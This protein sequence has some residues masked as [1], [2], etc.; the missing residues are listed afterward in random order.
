M[1]STDLLFGQSPNAPGGPVEIVFGD[2]DDATGGAV[3][4]RAS[5][6]IT[7]LRGHVVLRKAVQ[8]R[9]AGTITGLRGHIGARYDINVDRSMATA[10][11]QGWQQA[12]PLS[13]VIQGRYEQGVPVRGLHQ[14]VWQDASPLQHVLLSA[15][16]D[17]QR[18][19]RLAR[20]AWQEAQPLAPA[21]VL[22]AWQEAQRVRASALQR[23]EQ[24]QRVSAGTLQRYEE[25][26]RLRRATVQRFEQGQPRSAPVVTS[27]GTA[28][29]MSVLWV[30]RFEEARRPP[31]GITTTTQPQ[32]APCY[33][34]EL[35]THLVFDEPADSSLPAHLVFVCD[36]HTTDPEP[37]AVIV[38]PIKRYYVTLNNIALRRVDGDIELLAYGFTMSIDADSWTWSWSATLRR[39]MLPLLE[40]DSAGAV[41]L[42]ALVNGVP[43]RLMVEKIGRD[44]EFGSVRIRASGRGL[45]AVLASPNAPTMNFCNTVPRTAQQLMA[46]VLTVN[47]VPMGWGVDFGLTDWLVPADAWTLQGSHM[48]A[49]TDIAAAVGGYVQPHT[50]AQILRILPRYPAAPWAWGAITPGIELPAAAASVESIEWLDRPAYN[51]VFVGGVSQGVFGPFKRTGTAGEVLAPPVTNALITH[52]DAHRQRGIAE[53][54]NTGRQAHFEL[55]TMVHEATGLI[56]PGQFVRY[57]GDSTVMGIVRSTR[58]DWTRPLMHQT[59]GVE[60]HVA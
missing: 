34:P 21:P 49:I 56:L 25:A 44:K 42:E 53:I 23:F 12:R 41:E 54:S 26:A 35:P 38:I 57:V 27:M 19:A 48:D 9:A 39:D 52:A 55:K 16:Q 32:P 8:V 5:G 59:I 10:V 18:L 17:A 15:W 13:A 22:Q 37:G 2:D 24:G 33:V 45:A 36:R 40:P 4:L 1:S 6:R 11:Q 7:G 58:L 30:S 50:T 29:P 46:D 43:Y 14:S 51:R 3:E 28:V 60:T 20:Q 47:G 31:P